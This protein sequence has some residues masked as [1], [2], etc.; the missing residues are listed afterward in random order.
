MTRQEFDRRASVRAFRA[1][2]SAVA[3]IMGIVSPGAAAR[4]MQGRAQLLNLKRRGY[5][6]GQPDGP[7]QG[8]R[9]TNNSADAEYFRDSKLL[10]TRARDLVRNYPNIAGAVKRIVQNVVYTGSWP[11]VRFVGPDG[12][13]D[14]KT[15]KA[16]EK[17]WHAWA[18]RADATAYGS[19]YD[20]QALAVRHLIV[21]GGLLAHETM[22]PADA[23]GLPLRLSLY[24][25]DQLDQY[26]DGQ[27]SNG[28]L[29]RR[30]I[31]LDGLGR[32]V[33]YHVLYEH[34]GETI[35]YG[36]YAWRESRRIAS[37]V[38]ANLFVRERIG[39][40]RGVSWLASVIM[41]AFDLDEYQDYEMIGAKLAAA[42]GVFITT[43]SAS[44]YD[45]GSIKNAAG[46]A[47]EYIEPGRI[48]RLGPGEDVTI[49]E[50]KRPGESYEPFVRSKGREISAGL[51]MS[52]ENFS[53]DYSG[54]NYSSARQAI[55]EERRGY[56]CIQNH[57]DEHF[58]LWVWRR[59]VRSVVLSGAFR[60]PAGYSWERAEEFATFVRPGWE[61]IDPV[62]DAKGAETKV[63]LGISSRTREAANQGADIEE[64]AEEQEMEK[65]LFKDVQPAQ[66]PAADAP[67]AVAA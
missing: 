38:C 2:T 20:L 49:A 8:W 40:T 52:Y 28:N 3:G 4:Y 43:N 47:L 22:D 31:E 60:L 23:T 6:A 45:G 66:Q 65:E 56:R 24:E 57:L 58:N 11:Q 17:L 9:P 61:W 53:N 63:A 55:L 34:P 1:V 67:G 36:G 13:R 64:I 41:R 5:L 21:D 27:M 50:H 12:K 16:L 25:Y 32:P 29:A 35:H 14:K 48:Q 54:A 18:P 10:M 26:I 42:F 30:G 7:N 59:F 62:K 39:Q 15:S 19:I 37:D 44:D 46:Q 33:A 51:G